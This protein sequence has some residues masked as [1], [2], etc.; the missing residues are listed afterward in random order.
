[1]DREHLISRAKGVVLTP[2]SEWPV[3][4]G[5]PDSVGGLYARYIVWLAALPAIAGF[6]KS[7]I[8]GISVP[9]VG[10]V[11]VGMISGL[12]TM[13][14]Q[15]GLGLLTVY[16]LALLVNALAPTFGGRQDMTQ[17]LKATAYASTASWVAGVFV[18]VPWMGSLLALAGGIYSIYLLYLGLPA[19]M[20]S[21]QEKAVPY[22]AVTIIA[23]IVISLVLGAVVAK[24]SGV[25]DLGRDGSDTHIEISRNGD[26]VKID[27]EA[28]EKWAK[29]L[30]AATAK[31]EQAA[32]S[33]DGAD[34][35]QAMGEV[36]GALM[37]N[38]GKIEATDPQTLK[39]LLPETLGG[40]PRRSYN[41]ER[42]SA[43]GVQL[44][45][46]QARYADD[47]GTY[48]IELEISD[49]GGAQGLAVLAS[50]AGVETESES[51]SGY[52]RSRRDG[53]RMISE[54]WDATRQAGE[55]KLLLGKRFTVSLSGSGVGM[56]ALKDAAAAIDLGALEKLAQTQ[57]AK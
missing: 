17:A 4:A 28:V 39:G 3:I 37:G 11:R 33:G 29:N 48:A 21:P 57:A 8:I 19:T 14:L 46:A 27:D 55:Y 47:D 23:A 26:T 36:M 52:E 32:K 49:L 31:M 25:A 42:N 24:V 13:L 12:S 20:Q 56:D 34:Q 6:L 45:E 5:E 16:L 50:W 41:A 18:L 9:F 53:E 7:S 22:T 38:D 51:D 2:R 10:T 54:K 44:S 30:E 1:M 43:L 15:Y 40:Y 35:R